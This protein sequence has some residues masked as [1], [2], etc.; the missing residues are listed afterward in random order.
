M[1]IKRFVA[2]DMRTALKMVREEHGPDAV[3]LSNKP[4]HGGIEIVAATDYDEALV[5]QALRTAAE[6]P[7]RPATALDAMPSF[8]A[9]PLPVREPETVAA[10]AADARPVISR[11][12]AMIAALAGNNAQAAATRSALADRARAATRDNARATPA[13][14]AM[15]RRPA[16]VEAPVAEAE[17]TRPGD[18]FRALLSRLTDDEPTPSISARAAGMAQAEAEYVQTRAQASVEAVT[19]HEDVVAELPSPIPAETIEARIETAQPEPVQAEI[20]EP[21]QLVVPT[22]APTPPAPTYAELLAPVPAPVAAP[23]PT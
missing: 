11:A 18:D 3:I 8:V 10:N 15:L 7:E 21:V 5:Q 16:A 9:A 14:S 4:V 1:R 13:L 19:S 23:A 6:E 22:P 12:D 17:A 20:V 2:P